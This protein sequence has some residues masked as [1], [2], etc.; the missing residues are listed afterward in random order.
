M[1]QITEI[2][3]AFNGREALHI[4]MRSPS[5]FDAVLT[6]NNMPEMVGIELAENVRRLQKEGFMKPTTAVIMVSGDASYLMREE[7]LYDDEPLFDAFLNKPFA[8]KQLRQTLEQHA[9]LQ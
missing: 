4:I 2:S 1:L 6:D 7:L 9:L 5:A 3:K 8:L